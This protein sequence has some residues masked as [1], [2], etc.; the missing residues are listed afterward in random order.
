M[1]NWRTKKLKSLAEAFLSIKNLNTMENF[2]RDLGTAEEIE[3]MSSRWE[4]VLML[5]KGLPYREISKKTN[6]STTTIT[7]I[8]QWLN[9]GEGGYKAVLDSISKKE[10]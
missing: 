9:S 1:K 10:K 7:R 5:A 4:V 2:L 8:A 3:E 6:V